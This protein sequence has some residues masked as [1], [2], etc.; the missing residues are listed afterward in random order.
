M[1]YKRKSIKTALAILVIISLF[2]IAL[3]WILPFSFSFIVENPLIF[4]KLLWIAVLC[5]TVIILVWLT[6]LK[7]QKAVKVALS[8]FLSLILTVCAMIF[9]LSASIGYYDNQVEKTKSPISGNT[10]F[11]ELGGLL[12]APVCYEEIAPF[13]VARRN[14]K[15]AGTEEA[16]LYDYGFKWENSKLYVMYSGGAMDSFHM[17]YFD[18]SE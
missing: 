7:W 6:E 2:I 12:H 11:V 8:V 1:T 5:I 10:V 17:V 13:L 14:P 4:S 15:T 3:G 9:F 18:F 16:L